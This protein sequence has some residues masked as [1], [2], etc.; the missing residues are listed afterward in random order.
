MDDGSFH[1]RK[2]YN[3][4]QKHQ[5]NQTFE[6]GSQVSDSEFIK[7]V[8]FEAFINNQYIFLKDDTAQLYFAI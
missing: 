1:I 7:M 4:F 8:Y 5:T 6:R 2:G 3:I